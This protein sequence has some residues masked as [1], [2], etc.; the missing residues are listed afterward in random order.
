MK[1]LLIINGAKREIKALQIAEI[2]K[3]FEG[4]DPVIHYTTAPHEATT[5]LR[6]YLTENKDEVTVYACGGDGTINEVVNG[7]I[8]FPQAIMTIFP[9][10]TGNDFVKVYGG[11]AAYENPDDVIHGEIHKVDVSVL[12]GAEEG[13][14][15]SINVI[16]FGFDAVV[17]ERGAIYASQGKKNPFDRA[18][19]EAILKARRNKIEVYADGEKLNEK[20]MLLSCLAHGKYVG[21]KFCCAPKSDNEDGLM[22]VSVAHCMSLFSFMG[23]MKTYEVGKHLDDPK[24]A[25]RFSYRRAKEVRI[26][27]KKRSAICVDGEMVHGTDMTA[28]V[29]PGA[30]RLLCPKKK[31][32]AAE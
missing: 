32:P 31:E 19:P 29:I 15:A 11:V 22:D 1:H 24:T 16:N 28:T 5:F 17:G 3:H 4:L 14:I 6:E 21:G 12:K 7:L 20:V 8:G 26:V 27:C 9:I 13:E 10:G 2:L 30:I 18:I 25:K 23:L